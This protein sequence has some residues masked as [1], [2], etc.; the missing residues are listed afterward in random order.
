MLSA[1]ACRST[2]GT[3]NPLLSP[4]SIM[5]CYQGGD[6]CADGTVE[7]ALTTL[8]SKPAVDE[9]CMPFVARPGLGYVALPGKCE[10]DSCHGSTGFLVKAN[11]RGTAKAQFSSDSRVVASESSQAW[12][13][14]S[15]VE[16]AVPQS[17]EALQRAILSGGPV[18]GKINYYKNS[19]VGI[20][21]DPL[22]DPIST[23]DNSVPMLYDGPGRVAD[24][25]KPD[26]V[27]DVLVLGW[28]RN[29]N[30][31]PYWLVMDTI[32]ECYGDRGVFKIAMGVNAGNFEGYGFIYADLDVEK[33]VQDTAAA[34]FLGGCKRDLETKGTCQHAGILS[35]NGCQCKCGAKWA[36]ER[37]ESCRLQCRNG[38]IINN[39]NVESGGRSVETCR[40]DCPSGFAGLECEQT[41]PS[42]SKF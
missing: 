26:A 2:K 41:C 15:G 35:P 6:G 39:F 33:A 32:G 40:C 23:F 10:T 9:I 18:L 37:C 21:T 34:T 3:L 7:L 22:S 16:I 31:E 14:K 11:T 27:H 20:R 38:G 25:E 36:G 17:V 28:A 12:V 19:G 30:G 5:D 4:Q 42:A 29:N 8:E 24:D 13:Y 1:R